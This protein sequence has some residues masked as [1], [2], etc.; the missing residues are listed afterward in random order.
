M[1]KKKRP[2]NPFYLLLLG[3][4]TAF[5]VTAMAFGVMTVRGLQA[6]RQAS[7][8]SVPKSD[9]ETDSLIASQPTGFDH[10]MDRNGTKLMIAELVLLTVGTF[11]AIGY[12]QRL[13][14]MESE[15]NLE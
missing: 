7:Y 5:A 1:A 3:A 13:D 14:R 12:D 4:G 10:F 8:F 6:S 9:S 11:G 15:A 2:I